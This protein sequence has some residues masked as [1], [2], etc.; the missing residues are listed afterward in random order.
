MAPVVSLVGSRAESSTRYC[1]AVQSAVG[2]DPGAANPPNPAPKPL[3]A[4]VG[5]EDAAAADAAPIEK[6]GDSTAAD[7]D[8]G[9]LDEKMLAFLP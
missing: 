9:F 3:N 1:S 4:N 7:D 2:R 6:A 8:A 5:L